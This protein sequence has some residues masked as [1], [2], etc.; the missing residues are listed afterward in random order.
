MGASLDSRH[1]VGPTSERLLACC[2]ERWPHA[3]GQ[4]Q[5][6]TAMDAAGNESK[7]KRVRFR[8][9]KNRR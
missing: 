1:C 9:V 2:G 6:A 5:A 7:R 3:E 8:I 4:V